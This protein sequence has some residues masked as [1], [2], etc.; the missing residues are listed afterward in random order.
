M[1]ATLQEVEGEFCEGTRW[2]VKEEELEKRRKRGSLASTVVVRVK[3]EEMVRQLGQAG[4]WVGGYWCSVRRFVA[5]QPKRKT[6]GWERVWD[7]L[8]GDVGELKERLVKKVV[9]KEDRERDRWLKRMEEGEGT[10]L[11]SWRLLGDGMEKLEGMVRG[12][13]RGVCK[14]EVGKKAMERGERKL[15]E[16]KRMEEDEERSSDE[17]EG[18]KVKGNLLV[19]AKLFVFEPKGKK[20]DFG[21]GPQ[22]PRGDTMFTW[23]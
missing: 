9:V 19:F 21:G 16:L 5:V 3:G 4:V 22:S 15:G 7:K 23:G 20:V 12:V 10:V 13:G 1:E 6:R 11:A 18:E 17:E 8:S 14:K 2:L